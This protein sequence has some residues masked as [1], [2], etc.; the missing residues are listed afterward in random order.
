MM[1]Q[2]IYEICKQF[3]IGS[4]VV[5]LERIPRGNGYETLDVKTPAVVIERY[6]HIL[7]VKKDN[8]VQDSFT[9]A[10]IVLFNVLKLKR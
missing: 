2:E 6:P 3:K 4:K 9:Y 7:I 10:D 8:G 5:I 1:Q